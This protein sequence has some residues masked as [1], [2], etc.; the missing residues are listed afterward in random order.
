MTPQPRERYVVSY[1]GYG[2]PTLNIITKNL[3]LAMDGDLSMQSAM[4]WQFFKAVGCDWPPN[5]DWNRF[6]FK[7]TGQPG[8]PPSVPRKRT[9][10]ATNTAVKVYGCTCDR[11]PE[12]S[13][14][15]QEQ[16]GSCRYNC[17]YGT[18]VQ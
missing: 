3:N 5:W 14:C 8:R 6:E 16:H 1:P 17:L 4:A 12:C 9:V 2:N 11:D 15:D 7:A 13:N 18:R 10:R